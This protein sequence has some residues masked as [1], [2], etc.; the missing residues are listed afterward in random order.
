MSKHLLCD[1]RRALNG[2]FVATEAPRGSIE[3]LHLRRFVA[4]GLRPTAASF[5]TSHSS[6]R[7]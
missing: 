7:P 3:G 6:L 2:V 1:R 5:K 4:E